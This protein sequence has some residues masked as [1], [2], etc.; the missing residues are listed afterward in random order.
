MSVT[1]SAGT[2]RTLRPFGVLGVV[3]LLLVQPLAAQQPI[4]RWGGDS[5]GGAP[6]VESDPNDPDKVAGFDVEIA[7]LIA[8]GLGRKPKF[9][10]VAF[11][12]LDQSAVRGDFDIALSG[13]EDTPA[14]R[15]TVATSIPY[16][17]FREV[18]TVRARDRDRF[19]TLADLRG[20]KV[21]TL[22]GTIAYDLLLAAEHQQGIVA[23]S[24]DDDVHPYS[25][26]L[27]GRVDAVLLDNVLADRAMRRSGGLFT[28]PTSVQTAHYVIIAGPQNTA[29]RDRM[30]GILLAAMQDGRLERILRKWGVWNDEQPRLYAELA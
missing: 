1:A 18:L 5:E 10:Q 19:R 26:L 6:Y 15:A 9:V 14:R 30:N 21:A 7:E 11:A 12:S 23:V 22:S 20:H 25:D 29:L 4:L 28:E 3:A 27:V 2:R 8:Q 17:R 16:D 24:Y 13:I